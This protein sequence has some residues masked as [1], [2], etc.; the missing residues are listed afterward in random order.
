M[1]TKVPEI[2]N[3]PSKIR[4]LIFLVIISL[5]PLL[6]AYAQVIDVRKIIGKSHN[7]VENVLGQPAS[8]NETY[9]GL[10]C[11][12]EIAETE[13]IYIDG[14]ADWITV[15]GLENIEFNHG[16]IRQ[17]GLTP[18]APLVQNPFRM[19]WA[20]H[21]GLA[22]VSVYGSGKYVALIQVRAFT[23]Q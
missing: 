19:H 7:E 16:A 14:R 1:K 9:Q 15:S 10:S 12:Y 2:V 3:N 17:I 21:Q 18:A 20:S 5:L 11:N 8:C 6:P 4:K 13:V 22:V 23:P